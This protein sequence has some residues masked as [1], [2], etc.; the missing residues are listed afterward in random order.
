[1]AW[2]PK[3]PEIS[4][5]RARRLVLDMALIRAVDGVDVYLRCAMRKPTLIQDQALRSE[6]DRAN[7]SVFKKIVAVENAIP[8]LD[9]LLIAMVAALVSWRNESAHVEADDGLSERHRAIL[10][11]GNADIA[12]KFR[13]LDSNVM[14]RS[15][16]AESPPTFKEVASF[17]NA[18]HH[19]IQDLED[20][21]FARIDPEI[22]LKQLVGV[23]LQ[24][25]ADGPSEGNG[26]SSKAA[27]IWGRAEDDRPRYVRSFLQHNGLTL[28]RAK[29]GPSLKFKEETIKRLLSF[30]PK[31]LGIWLQE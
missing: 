2:S 9:P 31:E 17:I 6:I 13:G 25:R 19:F 20:Q 24:R 30:N 8:D 23:A 26:R 18:S 10:E 29:S 11:E 3:S 27:E 14:L 15:Y 28:E 12:S 5:R 7:R 21:L 16:D 4:A 1:M 22:F